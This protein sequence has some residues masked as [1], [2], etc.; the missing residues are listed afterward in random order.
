MT[1]CNDCLLLLVLAVTAIAQHPPQAHFDNATQI[2]EQQLIKEEDNY[3]DET[4][5]K[6]LSPWLREEA[7]FLK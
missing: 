7:Q 5:L 6:S 4:L 3:V 2:D 1:R